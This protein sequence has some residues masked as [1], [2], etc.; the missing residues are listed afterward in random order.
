METRGDIR[1]L[2]LADWK[3]EKKIARHDHKRER[4]KKR[5]RNLPVPSS[6]EKKGKKKKHQQ[7][8]S[9]FLLITH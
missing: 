4:K 1:T 7:L 2:L 5:N 8:R 9:T 6:S 3:K